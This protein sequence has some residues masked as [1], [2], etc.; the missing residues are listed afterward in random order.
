MNEVVVSV[1]MR[2]VLDPA[3]AAQQVAVL[4]HRSL[5]MVEGEP[6]KFGAII[7]A[8]AQEIRIEV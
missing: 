3:R 7:E 6:G 4:L 8:P 5:Y 1:T 2:N